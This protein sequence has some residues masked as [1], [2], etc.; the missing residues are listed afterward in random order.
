MAA[1]VHITRRGPVADGGIVY[2]WGIDDRAT[3][4]VVLR[5]DTEVVRPCTPSG[6]PIGTMLARRGEANVEHP[7][8]ALHR[9]FVVVIAALFRAWERTGRPPEAVTRTFW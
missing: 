8:P 3:G 9:D 7:D 4:H 2:G 6:V 1:S 5:A